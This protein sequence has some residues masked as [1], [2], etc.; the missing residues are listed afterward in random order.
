MTAVPA[1][2]PNAVL[3][4]ARALV[5]EIRARADEIESARR[6]PLDLVDKLRSTGIFR[7]GIPRTLD[8]LEAD[9]SIL[10][11]A[12]EE[13]SAA[14]GATGWCAM[15]GATSALVS[16]YLAEP[17]ARE[18]YGPMPV[19]SGGVF[20]P[21]GRA[22]I[23]GDD[24]VVTGRWPF[25]SG[26]EHCDWLMGGCVVFEGGK[27]KL[28]AGG[29]PQT[30]MV[31]FPAAAATIHDTW[32]VSGLR[33]T[34]SHDIEVRDV[35]VPRA[36]A[37]AL[38]TDRPSVEGAL[39]RFPVFGLLA[40]G[41][42]AVALGLARRAITELEAIAVDKTPTASRRRVAERA[43]V[44]ADVARAHA[45]TDA[46]RAYVFEAIA[47]AAREAAG[48]E[49]PI[50]LRGRLRLAASHATA[51]AAIAVDRMYQAGGGTSIYAGCALQRCFRDVHVATQHL[52]VAP[53]TFELVGR[54]LLGLD[55]ETSML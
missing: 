28:G 44:Q 15:I 51:S 53:P 55:A 38:A 41:I 32:N 16:G 4:R 20:A 35:R 6:L 8:G 26:C 25:A 50:M 17:V 48:G 1:R 2:E 37:L 43:A 3:E 31:L 19:I 46:A 5:P 24:F 13:V 36:R 52:M 42:A 12:I 47:G 49:I 7:L 30:T 45:E 9:P 34:G 21:K 39:Y 10:V 23:D 54:V 22:V 33:G 27:P 29:V 40:L 18:I 11:R 14:D